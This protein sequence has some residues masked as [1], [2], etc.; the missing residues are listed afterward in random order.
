MITI[1][2]S[3]VG[4]LRQMSVNVQVGNPRMKPW[5]EPHGDPLFRNK[6]LHK[7][8]RSR[9]LAAKSKPDTQQHG[10]ES[11]KMLKIKGVR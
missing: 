2:R 8:F 1:Q 6:M 7:S 10:D 3:I 5:L 9:L 11:Q 4:W